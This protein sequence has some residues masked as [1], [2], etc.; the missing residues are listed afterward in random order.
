VVEGVVQAEEDVNVVVKSSF[1]TD[2]TSRT[3]EAN[4][5][6]EWSALLCLAAVRRVGENR[7]RVRRISP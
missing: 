1:D 4:V 2:V 6:L 3:Q 7:A 5:T